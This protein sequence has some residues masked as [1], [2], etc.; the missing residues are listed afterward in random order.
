GRGTGCGART[1]DA[2]GF[3]RGERPLRRPRERDRERDRDRVRRQGEERLMSL[4]VCLAANT[5]SYPE[6]GGHPRVYLHRALRRRAR[7]WRG[8]RGGGDGRG[9]GVE[10][11]GPAV[12]SRL[13]RHGLAEWVALCPATGSRL[14]VGAAKGCL[15]DPDA[16]L[17]LNLQY[18]LHPDVVRRFRRSAL[19]DIDPGLLQVWWSGGS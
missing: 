10:A 19:I 2:R 3:S 16:D 6:G 14:A 15:E 9:L 1:G 17:L 5:L 18:S 7:V 11:V 12:K 4:T 8:E 13:R